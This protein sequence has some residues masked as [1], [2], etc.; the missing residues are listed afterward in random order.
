M[1]SHPYPKLIKFPKLENPKVLGK[2]SEIMQNT[3]RVL[4]VPTSKVQKPVTVELD[5]SQ[6]RCIFK[7]R[8]RVCKSLDVRTF[9]KKEKKLLVYNKNFIYQGL[10]D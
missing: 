10:N 2:F 9:I 5:W 1:L 3:L 8:R 4:S 7:T 6:E